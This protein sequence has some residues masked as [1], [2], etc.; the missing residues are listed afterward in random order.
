MRIP[1]AEEL[2]RGTQP[3]PTDDAAEAVPSRLRAVPDAWGERPAPP[4]PPA[5]TPR[6]SSGR[7]RHEE[8]ITVYISSGELVELERARLTLRASHSLA[9]DR[10]RLVREAVAAVLEDL[11][12]RGEDSALVRRLRAGE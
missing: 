2:L 9:V 1:A 12:V 6:R 10:G 5:P 3:E 8:K 11:D 4:P 7:E